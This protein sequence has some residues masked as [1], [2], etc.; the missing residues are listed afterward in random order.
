[1]DGLLI[2]VGAS[3]GISMILVSG[4]L[5]SLMHTAIPKMTQ[6]VVEL[7]RQ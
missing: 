3:A 6:I 4:E 1:M 7:P 2:V 5:S